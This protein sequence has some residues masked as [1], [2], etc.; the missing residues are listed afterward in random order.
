MRDNVCTLCVSKELHTETER[1]MRICEECAEI[2]GATALPKSLR[3]AI[4]CVRCQGTELIRVIPREI[5][6]GGDSAR[7]RQL[8]APMLAT[9]AIQKTKRVVFSGN[10]VGAPTVEAGWGLMEMV[11]CRGCGFTEWYCHGADE[12]P[13]GPAFNSELMRVAAPNY[14]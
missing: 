1:A 12:I 13:I 8:A 2:T 10:A 5:T 14:R 6:A 7:V 9:F 4:P 3:P 11:I